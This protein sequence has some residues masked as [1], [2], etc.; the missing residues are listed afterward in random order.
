MVP[1]AVERLRQGRRKLSH[2]HRTPIAYLSES[3]R[4]RFGKLLHTFRKAIAYLSERYRI[5]FGKVSHSYR[6]PFG[7]LSHTFRN[8][9][10]VAL[11]L[12]SARSHERKSHIGTKCLAVVESRQMSSCSSS[13]TISSQCRRISIYGDSGD[14]SMTDD[15]ERHVEAAGMRIR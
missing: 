10:T 12:P 9:T 15:E 2:T 13:L 1:Y 6:I 11:A 5:P 8:G 14:S 4:I 3:Y 7:K